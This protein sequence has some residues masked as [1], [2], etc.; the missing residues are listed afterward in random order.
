MPG[1]SARVTTSWDGG[2]P[3]DLKIA[4]LLAKHSLQGTFY[5]PVHS[6]KKGQGLSDSEIRHIGSCFE[7][8]AHTV[9]HAVL[10]EVA[11]AVATREIVE[12]KR[13]LENI[14]GSS[15]SM[16]CFP[17]GAYH[18]RHLAMLWAA[19]FR[20]ARTVELLSL[21][22]PRHDM[23]IF[24]MPTTLQVFD[25]TRLTYL[26]NLAKR[27]AYKNLRNWMRDIRPGDFVLTARLLL[28]S[29]I[30]TG[31]VFHL[32]GHSWEIDDNALW[33]ELEQ[34][35]ALMHQSNCGAPCIPN[36]RVCDHER[37]S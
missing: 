7:I 32:W 14:T 30:Q 19:G 29:A 24:V 28:E 36:S 16:F 31:G 27:G 37:R 15:C 26:K 13:Y 8:G 21:E 20:G 17:K 11:D 5:L 2:H 1:N 22:F 10:T 25:H 18:R 9:H 23:G 33:S 4:D 3:L 34:V 6:D 35:F 12:S